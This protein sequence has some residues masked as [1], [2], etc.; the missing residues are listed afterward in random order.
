[1][2]HLLLVVTKTFTK[3]AWLAAVLAVC[4][5]VLGSLSLRELIYL[6]EGPTDSGSVN[7]FHFHFAFLATSWV[8]FIAVC[9]Q[10]L[11]GSQQM[12][13]G[14]P[15]SSARI[16][17][18]LMFSS[19]GVVVLL[20]LVTN[21]L[22]RLVFF[23]EHW[24]ADYWP[25]LGPLLFLCTLVMVGYHCFWSMHAPGFLKVAGWGMAFGLLFYWF[26]SRYYPHGFAKGVVPWSHV[27]L[28]EFVT[29]QLVSLVAWLGGVR[30]YSN[31]RN[32]AAM[33]SPQWDQTQ[34][35]W[36]ALITG[37]IPERMSVPLSRRMTLARMHWSGSCQR[38]VIVGGILFGVAVLIVNL[39]AAAMYDSSSP[40]LN[41]LLELSETF[42][43]STLVLSGIAAIG[44]TIM[45]AGSV[46]GTG[47]TEMNRSLAM[48]PLSD[49]ELSASL[50]GN[51]WK[52]CLACSVMLQLALLLSYAGFLMMQGT[53]IV[54][55]NYDMGEWL[56][57]NL[58]YSS[59]AMIGSWILTANLLALCW[60][61]RQ[62]VCNTVVG[63]VVGG[64]VTF[65]IISQILRSSGFYQ[66]AQLLEKSVF[67]V[68]TL[69]IISATIGAWLD[70]GKR[71]LIRKR[72]RNAA[73]CCSIA[74]LVLF[75]TWV[76]RQTVGPDH[77]IGF[78]WI[79][80][81]IALILAPFATIPLALSWNRHR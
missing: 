78:L 30:A 62:W 71:C 32:G 42:Q 45:L 64:S 31:I 69:S 54:H 47:N 63:V 9:L 27:T 19:V 21:G 41:N 66:A 49:R 48:T 10:A 58:I 38:A 37:R 25:V 14:L 56:K 1:M 65:M 40:E 28:T 7:P 79:A 26:V 81:L 8:T 57:Q 72:T 70:A 67:L 20:S 16:A 74:G 13:R 77:W 55:S 73:L 52:T 61:G 4:L 43:V 33:P 68:M 80:T 53:E 12:I 35:W 46:A 18:G 60:T 23:D 11:Q 2:T 36:T 51:M 3:R 6:L 50:F 44:V 17:S 24:L 75:K 76:F 5:L 39:A 29:L 59:V 15:I 34:L 22:Y